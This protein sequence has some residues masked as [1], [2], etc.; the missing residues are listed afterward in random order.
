METTAYHTKTNIERRAGL[1]IWFLL[2]LTEGLLTLR[3]VFKAL[4]VAAPFTNFIY[5]VTKALVAPFLTIAPFNRATSVTTGTLE[6]FTL[7]AMVVFWMIAWAI[8]K[9]VEIATSGQSEELSYRTRSLFEQNTDEPT[10]YEDE[11]QMTTY[12]D[13]TVRRHQPRL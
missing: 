5:Q 10:Y 11:P 8:M 2:Y 13:Y 4:G 1:I 9:L 3:F 6:W 7:A 12:K